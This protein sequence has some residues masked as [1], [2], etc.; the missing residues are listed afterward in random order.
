MHDGKLTFQVG[1]T[2]Y[3]G[4][5]VVDGNFILEAA[6]YLGHDKEAEE[7]LRT[8]WTRQQSNGQIIAGS[9]K[10]HWKDTAIAMFTLVR[11]CELSQDWTLLRELEP[12]V[13][14][15]IAFLRSLQAEATQQDSALGRYGLLPRA[16]Q[17]EGSAGPCEELT[18]TLWV[19]AGLKA[20]ARSGRE[21][22]DRKPQRRPRILQPIGSRISESCARA[23]CAVMTADSNF[24]PCC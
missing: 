3:R 21:R 20:I 22:E 9:G 2:C 24:S 8:T 6:R 12:Q 14:R 13:L 11:Q 10:Q 15:A 5:W 18:N 16:W 23:K 4:L 1:P 19:L 17:T 7:G